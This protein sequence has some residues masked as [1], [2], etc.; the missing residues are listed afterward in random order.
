MYE[1]IVRVRFFGVEADETLPTCSH[2]VATKRL[3]YFLKKW[4]VVEVRVSNL[5]SNVSQT[6]NGL[7]H[8][9]IFQF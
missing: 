6:W 1:V 9:R 7:H 5:L 8:K 2:D 3:N 4:Y